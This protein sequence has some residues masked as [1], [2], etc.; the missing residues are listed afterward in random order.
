MKDCLIKLVLLWKLLNNYI[1][2]KDSNVVI[3][4]LK[5]YILFYYI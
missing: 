1:M 4:S 5:T 2:I 3:L